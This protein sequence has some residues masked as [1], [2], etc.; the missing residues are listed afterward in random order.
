MMVSSNTYSGRGAM[1]NPRVVSE[2]Q[3]HGKKLS[4]LTQR[5][6]ER[7]AVLAVVRRNLPPK[8][9]PRVHSAG[10]ENGRLT[11]GVN[12]AAWASRL[13]YVTTDLRRAVGTSL[14]VDIVSVRI[15][16]LPPAATQR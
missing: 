12:G 9:A 13:R 8:L 11:L 4:E 15:R 2:L 1:Q 16:V 14:G 7:A 10:L 5:L 6:S 3:L